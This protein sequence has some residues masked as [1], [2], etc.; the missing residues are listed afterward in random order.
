MNYS[1]KRLK[2]IVGLLALVAGG[3]IA[4]SP[5]GN[6]LDNLA[7]DLNFVSSN[8][9][10]HNSDV[11]VVA[12]DEPSFQELGLA[13]PWPRS[14]HA[15]L[16]ESLFTAGAKAV[17][18]D[19]ILADVSED[20]A[21][22]ASTLQRRGP[23]ILATDVETHST[24]AFQRVISVQ[25][26]ERFQ[27][28]NVILGSATLPVDA[29]GFV[30]RFGS[31]GASGEA[32]LAAAAAK[33]FKPELKLDFNAS[34]RGIN[35][36]GAAGQLPQYSYY[37]ALQPDRYLPP[38]ALANKLVFVGLVTQSDVLDQSA[39][40]DSYPTPHTTWGAGYMNGVEI[41]AQAAHSLL[42]SSSIAT[43]SAPVIILLSL[44]FAG[45]ALW[46]MFRFDPIKAALPA[47]VTIAI[48]VGFCIWLMQ[49][50]QLYISWPLL[51]LPAMSI[52]LVSPLIHYVTAWQ[53]RNFIHK[54][55]S[56][57][58]AEPVV[59]Q[60][61][62]NPSLL[63]PGGS[64]QSGTVLFLDL[65]GFT[66]ISEKMPPEQLVEMLNQYLGDLSDIAIDEGGMID[67]FIGDAIMV[68]WGAPLEDT[69]HAHKACIVALKMQEYLARTRAGGANATQL[70]ARIGIHSGE[71]VAGNIGGQRKF[72][73]TVI[74]DT[75]NL[76]ARLESANSTL[77]TEI[78]IS[79]T[80]LS[81]IDQAKFNTR[82][83]DS[84]QVKGREESVVVYELAAN[85]SET[86][87]SEI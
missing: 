44:L 42:Q 70:F 30:R 39:S 7:Y 41:H 86:V 59:A 40:R 64:L 87:V 22:L 17:V 1:S 28:Q 3:L 67:K 12:I 58:L 53:E 63:K 79:E 18:L 72:D 35:Y 74:G 29:D 9:H 25:P 43:V 48:C 15:H 81:S 78:L 55:F 73:Y 60:L 16:I 32:S 83:I 66:A 45:I 26:I 51:L 8:N 52:S 6:A 21:T 61:M 69:Q 71:F 14:K 31:A 5:I 54:A 34:N 50:Q 56:A 33:V 38:N 46:G 84:I 65:Q 27:A 20:D 24:S 19:L 68:V 10:E 82:R 37:Q 4:L 13:W 2:I 11:V 23:V 80:T 49:S 77:G 76:A 75:V 85:E 62:D 36:V 47:L 57:Y